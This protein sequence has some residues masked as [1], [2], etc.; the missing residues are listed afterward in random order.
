MKVDYFMA[1][2]TDDLIDPKREFIPVGVIVRDQVDVVVKLYDA[3][4]QSYIPNDGLS[5]MIFENLEVICK[6][7]RA[8]S[9]NPTNLYFVKADFNSKEADL[10]QKADSFYKEVIES[11]YETF[12][13]S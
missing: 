3:V 4:P 12:N 7:V 2:W 8:S 1:L 9:H 6:D 10:L 11:F 5:K 13:D